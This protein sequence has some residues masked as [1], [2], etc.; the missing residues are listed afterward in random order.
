MK[1]PDT[2]YMKS[3][4]AFSVFGA[5]TCIVVAFILVT[6]GMKPLAIA[7]IVPVAKLTFC[8]VVEVREAAESAR[9]DEEL[10]SKTSSG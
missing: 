2:V 5:V 9:L 6:A 3:K 10:V 7:M 1:H 4:A 8:S